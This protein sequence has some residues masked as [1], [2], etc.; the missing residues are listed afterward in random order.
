MKAK[1]SAH[2]QRLNLGEL[3]FVGKMKT[4][5]YGM[6]DKNQLNNCL[7]F[8]FYR[9]FCWFYVSW[10]TWE[11]NDFFLTEWITQDKKNNFK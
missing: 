4:H 11:I 2:L 10:D 8:Y 7:L 9:A 6:V 1:Q 5:G 3:F